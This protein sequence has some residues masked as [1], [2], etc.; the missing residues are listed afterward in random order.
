MF[1]M[2][3]PRQTAGANVIT[4]H[5]FKTA[6]TM[7]GKPRYSP[8]LYHMSLISKPICLLMSPYLRTEDRENAESPFRAFGNQT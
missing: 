2:P 3:E 4:H 6:T 7:S 1:R 5:T 8:R